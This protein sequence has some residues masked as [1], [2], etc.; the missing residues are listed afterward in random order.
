MRLPA[1]ESRFVQTDEVL[2][3]RLLP[4]RTGFSGSFDKLV[5]PGRS[6]Q[7]HGGIPGGG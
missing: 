5:H 1:G 2:L 4:A 6:G 7:A 3:I